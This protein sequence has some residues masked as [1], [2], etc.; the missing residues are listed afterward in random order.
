MFCNVEKDAVITAKDVET[1]YEVPIVFRKE[2][3]DE[4]IVR[5][6][7]LETGP[8]NL[9]EWDAMVQKIKYPKHESRGRA[10]RQVCG[11]EGMLQESRG[12]ARP[13]RHRP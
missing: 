7:R 8:P 10:G 4:L 9:R 2:G 5:Q 13:W 11:I 6:L 1:I 3:L 12:I